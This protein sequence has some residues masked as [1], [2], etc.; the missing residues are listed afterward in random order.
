MRFG[1]EIVLG[2]GLRNLMLVYLRAVGFMSWVICF[3]LGICVCIWLVVI[4][5]WF[6]N[7]VCLIVCL[8]L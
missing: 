7:F 4:D 5:S 1:F 2:G 3:C 8:Y 6:V